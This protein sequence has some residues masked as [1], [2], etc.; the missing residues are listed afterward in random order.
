MSGLATAELLAGKV[1]HHAHHERQLDEPLR[2][3]RI[4]VCYV[5]ARFAV[6]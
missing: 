5:D 2:I 1:G 4:F 6:A 3:V